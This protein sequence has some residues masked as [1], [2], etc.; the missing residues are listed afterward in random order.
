MAT[1]DERLSGYTVL[2]GQYGTVRP[3]VKLAF[4][5]FPDADGNPIT[6][7]VHPHASDIGWTEFIESMRERPATEVDE[8]EVLDETMAYVR[9]QIHPDDWDLFWATAKANHQNSMDLVILAQ[10]IVAQVAGFPTGRP[11]DSASGPQPTG[12][13]SKGGLQRP[14]RRGGGKSKKDKQKA[15]QRRVL[16]RANEEGRSDLALN[17]LEAYEA[18][19]GRHLSIVDGEVVSDAESD[20]RA[21]RTA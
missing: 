13:L 11:D 6:I 16:A 4:P 2:K 3:E 9:G 8:G 15:A 1:Q 21:S 19:T 20:E 14:A 17:V 10:D 5:Y 12:H 7:R 18:T